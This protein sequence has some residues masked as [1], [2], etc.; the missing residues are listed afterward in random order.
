MNR[1][2][3]GDP[4]IIKAEDWNQ[5]VDIV[6][7]SDSGPNTFR[8][9]N[10]VQNRSRAGGDGIKVQVV[11]FKDDYLECEFF[12]EFKDVADGRVDVA[13]PWMLRR[14]PF[15]GETIDY[16]GQSIS[17]VYTSDRERTATGA[18]SETQVMTADYYVGESLTVIPVR[19][20]VELPDGSLA[21]WED[22]NTCGRFWAQEA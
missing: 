1:V 7:R 15:D 22:I 9:G 12:D 5:I 11:D 17:Y 3:P 20:G 14:T 18:T 13:K 19:T 21:V 8:D 10:G 6:N 4:L 16:R 2:R